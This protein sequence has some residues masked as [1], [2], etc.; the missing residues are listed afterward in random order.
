MSLA[1]GK[2]ISTEI[3]FV[4]P[5]KQMPA[6]IIT[7]TETANYPLC[8]DSTCNE[9]NYDRVTDYC[10]DQDLIMSS[11][12]YHS[13]PAAH[14]HLQ[15]SKFILS[16][17]LQSTLLWWLKELKTGPPTATDPDLMLS[18]DPRLPPPEKGGSGPWPGNLYHPTKILSPSSLTEALLM[19][20]CQ[21]LARR[22]FDENNG[23]ADRLWRVW[24]HMLAPLH[25]EVDSAPVKNVT[26]KF[27][28]AW[29]CL[30][31]RMPEFQTH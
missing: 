29:D 7:L 31:G 11:N 4:I 13:V 18:N 3:D 8:R 24:A 20:F 16:L 15:N 10:Q 6:A 14:F 25:D 17:H 26:P 27:K 23:E 5:K 9:L 21:D 22:V 1:G 12:R 28:E 30:N 2:E 19:L